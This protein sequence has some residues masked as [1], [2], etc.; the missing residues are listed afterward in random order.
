MG[1]SVLG[2]DGAPVLHLDCFLTFTLFNTL[3]KYGKHGHGHVKASLV[4]DVL[5]SKTSKIKV[6]L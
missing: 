3:L 2:E 5:F 1:L 4:R 6:H